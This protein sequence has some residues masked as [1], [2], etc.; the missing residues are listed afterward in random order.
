MTKTCEHLRYSI[1]ALSA[2][3]LEKKDG[4]F[5]PSLSLSLYQEAIH[6]LVPSLNV[7]DVTIVASC[8]ILAVLE[9]FSCELLHYLRI[10]LD[11][12]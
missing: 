10:R 1:L 12:R 4:T 11:E 5:P 9:M 6:Q 7:K 2:R 8:V 3:Q